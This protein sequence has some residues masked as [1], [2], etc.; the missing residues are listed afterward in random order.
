MKRGITAWLFNVNADEPSAVNSFSLKPMSG[1]LK[2]S[3]AAH[4]SW[5]RPM[6]ST[7]SPLKIDVLLT[8]AMN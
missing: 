2:L 1:L 5:T 4:N 7:G 8:V 6:E 3:S